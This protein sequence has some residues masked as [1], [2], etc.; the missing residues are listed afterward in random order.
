MSLKKQTGYF[1]LLIMALL[2]A[3]SA[4][5]D[6]PD[7]DKLGGSRP[8]RG[9]GT[10]LVVGQHGVLSPQRS[11]A[12]LRK[13]QQEGKTGLLERHLAFMQELDPAPLLTGNAV[14]LLV[15]GAATYR[16]MFD[17]IR[18]ARDHVNLETYIFDE[19]GFGERLGKLLMEKQSQGVQVNL[20]YDS[21]GSLSTRAEFF[22]QLREAGINICE[23]NPVN[24]LRGSFFSLNNR[25]HRKILV[26]DGVLGYTGGINI[27]SVYSSSA[28]IRAKRSGV[29]QPW[30]DTQIEVRGPAVAEFQRLFLDS[31]HQQE[32]AP[33]AQKNYFPMLQRQGDTVLRIL[34]STPNEKVNLIYVELLS[35]L[36]HAER[37]IHLTSAYFA[38]DRQT[39]DALKAAVQRGVEV[40]LALAGVSDVWI[41][42]YAGR[43]YYDELLA[44]GV[45]I[46]ERQDALLHAKTAVIDGVWSTVGSSNVD[47]RS[48]L[49]NDE[50]NVVVLG[51]DFALQMERM[52]ATDV[53]ASINIEAST[54]EKR[55]MGERLRES[56]ARMWAYFL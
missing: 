30:R 26:A 41:A 9:T 6:L 51:E 4:C 37:S 43:S 28:A 1:R 45:R 27:S 13:I 12:I 14:R 19:E 55:G 49:H 21:L 35:A 47:F 7:I 50:V 8:E 23:F 5:A 22:E 40:Q 32:C 39:V 34:G 53:A 15:D 25:D 54:W 56:L 17:A 38:P 31:W 52:F 48:F 24:P 29:P 44:A 46:Y 20:I 33:L 3:L 36:T 42:L 16:A 2:W 10:P 18:R 11:A